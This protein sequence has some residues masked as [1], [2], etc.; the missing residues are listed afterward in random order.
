MSDQS[1]LQQ[2]KMVD[3]FVGI[4]GDEYGAMSLPARLAFGLKSDAIE[5]ERF[6]AFAND[7]PEVLLTILRLSGVGE[8]GRRSDPLDASYWQGVQDMAKIIL[9]ISA[10]EG[11]DAQTNDRA[12]DD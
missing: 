2:L 8:I 1:I 5:V 7:Y 9:Q 10:L 11:K 4:R 3:V 6:K 12:T